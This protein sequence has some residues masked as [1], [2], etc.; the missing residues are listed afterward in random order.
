[1]VQKTRHKLV[2]KIGLAITKITLTPPR[3]EGGQWTCVVFA[4]HEGRL[5]RGVGKGDDDVEARN[6]AFDV[7]VDAIDAQLELPW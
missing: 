5:Y 4:N 1:M 3:G 2:Q 7:I 6:V